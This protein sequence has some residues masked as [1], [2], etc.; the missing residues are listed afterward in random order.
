[1]SLFQDAEISFIK[2]I[3]RYCKPVFI[4]KDEF[5]IKKGDSS[6]SVSFEFLIKYRKSCYVNFCVDVFYYYG[7]S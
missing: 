2:L 5:I 1:M 7:N 4:P 6:P 3:S